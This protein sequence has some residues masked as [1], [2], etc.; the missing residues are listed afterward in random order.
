MAGFDAE[1][2][3]QRERARAASRFDADIGQRIRS[4][5]RVTF[6]GYDGVEA[7]A[8]VVALHRL[9]GDDVRA[10]DALEPGER[11][12]VLLDRTPFYAEAGGQ[13]G[14]KG[15]LLGAGVEFRVDDTTPSGSQHLHRGAVTRGRLRVGDHVTAIVAGDDRRR[16]AANHSATHL[17]HAA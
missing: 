10:V 11:G 14:D 3:A 13:V 17:L 6:L 8:N 7:T 16:T 5:T 1:M 2:N 15:R 4:D 9:E 12:V